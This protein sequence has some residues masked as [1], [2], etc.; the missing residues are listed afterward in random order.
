M[1]SNKWDDIDEI[2]TERVEYHPTSSMNSMAKELGV[3]AMITRCYI[4]KL[5]LRSTVHSPTPYLTERTKHRRVEM[6]TNPKQQTIPTELV[7]HQCEKECEPNLL[8][9][10]LTLKKCHEYNAS[11]ETLSSQTE[12]NYEFNS[13]ANDKVGTIGTD[14]VIRSYIDDEPPNLHNKS[15]TNNEYIDI[16]RE[17]FTPR[18]LAHLQISTTRN[19][20][21]QLSTFGIK[22]GFKPT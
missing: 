3:T 12:S 16:R 15:R 9:T 5:G 19:D 20:A 6:N 7:K 4:M 14:E 2:L 22:E 11:P 1:R 18:G 21:I 17:T 8:K 10:M 13:A